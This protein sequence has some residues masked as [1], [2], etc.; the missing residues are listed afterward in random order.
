MWKWYFDDLFKPMFL[1]IIVGLAIN[2]FIPAAH[3]LASQF[4]LMIV[5][6]FIILFLS[7]T[8]APLVRCE[9]YKIYKSIKR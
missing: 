7:I 3:S 8:S 1:P 4:I 5:S 2:A 6:A 9:F